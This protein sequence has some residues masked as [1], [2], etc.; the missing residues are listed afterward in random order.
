MEATTSEGGKTEFITQSL[1]LFIIKAVAPFA[2]SLYTNAFLSSLFIDHKNN[3]NTRGQTMGKSEENKLKN[4]L[5][6]ESLRAGEKRNKKIIIIMNEIKRQNFLI[7]VRC[8]V[9][10]SGY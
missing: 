4:C 3:K 5:Y 10:V 8:A 1:R 9:M 6:V 2:D 7:G